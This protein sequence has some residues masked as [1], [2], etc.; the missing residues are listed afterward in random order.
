MTTI[1]INGGGLA[2]LATA[3]L[4]AADGHRVT[5][6]ERDPP[7]PSRDPAESWDGWER[8]A[9]PQFRQT[10]AYLARARSTLMTELPHVWTRL[11]E[12]GIREHNLATHPPTS[13]SDRA[14]R[15]GD[16]QLVYVQGRRSTVETVVRHAAEDDP[17]IE[18]LA[19][20]A[21]K[22][23]LG[24]VA[25]DSVPL[26]RGLATSAGPIDAALVIDC[27][28]RRSSMPDWIEDLGGRRPLERAA[29]YRIAYWTQW[30]RLR[31]GATM[32]DLYGRP[33]LEVGPIEILRI[34]ADD[35]WFSITIVA[36]ADDQRF[37]ALS[38][39]TRLMR[40][41]QALSLTR[42]WVDP[43]VAVP[44]GGVQPM[45]T[46]V[47]QR[48]R[49][50]VDEQPCAHNLVGIGDAVSATNPSLARGTTFALMHAVGLRDL[51]RTDADTGSIAQRY[52]DY[53]QHQFEPWFQATIA[54]D[55]AHLARMRAAA[56]RTTPTVDPGWS[57]IHAA[58][59]DPDLWRLGCRIA[60]VLDLPSDVVAR[61]GV[62]E[63]LRSVTERVG[64]PSLAELDVDALLGT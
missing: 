39:P 61:P 6:V 42:D 1:A 55:Q 21:A 17:L 29:E 22:G 20:T 48:R 49:F 31:P 4:L 5:V 2:G 63:Q 37:R 8:R 56:E 9:V 27:G 50:V 24:R 34:P 32:P 60:G 54:A 12:A 19:G 10:H 23:L 45:F 25:G 15:D 43:T 28:G 35:G 64:P 36:T 30:F 59:H 3:L 11:L 13:I 44:V 33:A 41:L 38:D 14:S 53:Q 7:P 62:L 47:D 52:D 57:F 46:L 16:E 40:F 58:N 18:V 51:L 26:V